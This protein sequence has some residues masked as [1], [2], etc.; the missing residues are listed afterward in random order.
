[1]DY[2][3]GGR[4]GVPDPIVEAI[5]A[6]EREVAGIVPRSFTMSEIQSRILQA[7]VSE[8]QKNSGRK[9]RPFCS[10]YRY[11]VHP[12]IRVFHA[13]EVVRCLPVV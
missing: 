2:S 13:G 8:G 4:K 7:M 3:G 11:G 6:E 9:N 10:G 12:W 1:M 5:I